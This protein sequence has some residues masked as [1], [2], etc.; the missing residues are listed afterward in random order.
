MK[1]FKNATIE[2]GMLLKDRDPRQV[3]R[4]GFIKEIREKNL[5]VLW[6]TNRA[7]IVSREGISK[8][9]ELRPKGGS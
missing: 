1:D 3:N 6:N 8:R 4:V 9:Y 7:T 5:V 2:I